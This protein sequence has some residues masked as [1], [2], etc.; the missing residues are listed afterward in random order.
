MRR[1]AQIVVAASLLCAASTATAQ[2]WPS[3]DRRSGIEATG[4]NDAAL[5]VAIED[6]AFLPD[7]PGAARNAADW[8]QFLRRDLG[9]RTV[10]TLS[11]A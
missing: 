10:L 4:S 1:F 8:Q 2:V 3:F 6:Y 11:N 7:V 5:I 9:V